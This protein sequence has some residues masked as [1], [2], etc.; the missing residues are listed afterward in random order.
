VRAKGLAKRPSDVSDEVGGMDE[1]VGC[2][3]MGSGWGVDGQTT[4]KKRTGE[5]VGIIY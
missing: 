3:T 4:G 5:Y 1:L 2:V